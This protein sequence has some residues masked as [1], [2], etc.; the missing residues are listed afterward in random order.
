M[1]AILE[2]NFDE[3]YAQAKVRIEACVVP[4]EQMTAFTFFVMWNTINQIL[5]DVFSNTRFMWNICGSETDNE[6]KIRFLDQFKTV[7]TNEIVVTIRNEFKLISFDEFYKMSRAEANQYLKLCRSHGYSSADLSRYFGKNE[8]YIAS[9]CS[10]QGET[11]YAKYGRE[12][13]VV[14][15]TLRRIHRENVP[16]VAAI[17]EMI[18]PEYSPRTAQRALGRIREGKL[19]TQVY[20]DKE[21]EEESNDKF[22]EFLRKLKSVVDDMIEHDSSE[23]SCGSQFVRPIGYALRLESKM[24]MRNYKL[25]CCYE[26]ESLEKLKKLQSKLEKLITAPTK[27]EKW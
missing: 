12:P 4:V 24:R 15:E 22:V 10:K 11:R 16:F 1:K 26:G 8:T 21:I 6:L 27:E 3:L 23:R 17:C 7:S 2:Q 25:V 14:R 18:F 9:R 5:I 20:V 13:I 19:I